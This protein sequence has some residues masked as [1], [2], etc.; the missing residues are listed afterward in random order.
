[1]RAASI[2]EPK[3]AEVG[4]HGVKKWERMELRYV[5]RVAD[6]VLKSLAGGDSMGF[7]GAGA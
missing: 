4:V 5:G 6:V 3:K 2:D 7:K 1:V